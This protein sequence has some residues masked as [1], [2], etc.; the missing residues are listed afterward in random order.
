MRHPIYHCSI[1]LILNDSRESHLHV[2][3]L[4]NGNPLRGSLINSEYQIAHYTDQPAQVDHTGYLLK[5]LQLHTRRRHSP[6]QLQH[7]VYRSH[8]VVDYPSQK[9][10]ESVQG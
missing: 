10:S 3:L 1:T 5:H 2:A 4:N 6:I 7:P 8:A 9:Y